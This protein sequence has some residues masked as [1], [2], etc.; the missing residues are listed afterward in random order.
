MNPKTSLWYGV[1]PLT[2][3]YPSV[4]GYVYCVGNPVKLIDPDGKKIDLSN[5]SKQEKIIS[6]ISA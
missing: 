4:S 2:E 6:C 1:D 5:M 3:K